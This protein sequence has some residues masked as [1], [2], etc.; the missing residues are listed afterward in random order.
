MAINGKVSR[1]IVCLLV[2]MLVLATTRVP[3][4]RAKI[5]TLKKDPCLGAVVVDASSGKV[6]IDEGADVKGYPAS[7]LKLMNLLILL[8][9]IEAKE[10]KLTDRVHVTAEA[11]RMGG[12][13]VYLAEK[14]VFSVEDMLYA[15]MVQSAN[16]AAVAL[17]IHI[18]GSKAAFVE[19]MNQRAR[20]L[21]MKSTVFHSVHGLPPDEGQK[22]DISTP[23]D[24]ALL[25]RELLK[26]PLALK[27]TATRVRP[28]RTEA[29]EPFI[30]RTHNN[31][32]ASFEGCDGLKTGYFRAAGFSIA[33]TAERGGNRV[34]AIVLGSESKKIRDAHT[35]ELLDKGFALLASGT[36]RESTAVASEGAPRR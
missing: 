36:R 20:R 28:F 1:G 4:K 21:G 5:E 19:L 11:A 27:L 13:Q 17:A 9:K 30:M 32:L 26:H 7:M 16:D 35:R 31:L 24:M 3:A 29:K 18:T 10:L 22:P 14:E 15:M 23:R 12:S 33:A 2:G 8:E 34:L 6:L 25:C